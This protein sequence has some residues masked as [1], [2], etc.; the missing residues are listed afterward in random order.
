MDNG[1]GKH[2]TP[3]PHCFGPLEWGQRLCQGQGGLAGGCVCPGR[4]VTAALL[5]ASH[6]QSFL[7]LLRVSAEGGLP[8]PAHPL[9][10]PPECANTGRW[11]CPACKT[12]QPPHHRAIGLCPQ[13]HV[14]LPGQALWAVGHQAGGRGKGGGPRES[15]LPSAFKGPLFPAAPP[16]SPCPSL[17]G[18]FGCVLDNCII[19]FLFIV[20]IYAAHLVSDDPCN[21]R[22]PGSEG[23]WPEGW[24]ALVGPLWAGGQALLLGRGQPRTCH[25]WAD[26]SSICRIEAGGTSY[27]WV[28]VGRGGAMPPVFSWFPGTG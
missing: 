20:F 17:T 3:P 28:T 7:L 15:S 13:S 21:C 24:E 27:G 8:H 10:P 6:C 9:P 2:G 12:P 14:F 16:C 5:I 18:P 1:K 23:S 25:T 22:A 11:P 19:L 4:S 26:G